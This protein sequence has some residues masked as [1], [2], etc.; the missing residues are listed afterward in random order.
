MPNVLTLI[1]KDDRRDSSSLSDNH[2]KERLIFA[3]NTSITNLR[4]HV[5]YRGSLYLWGLG[6]ALHV[7]GAVIDATRF[8]ERWFP[9]K[10]DTLVSQ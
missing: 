10:F 3:I 7:G 8:P 6:G 2:L 1:T 4:I 5:T 9:G